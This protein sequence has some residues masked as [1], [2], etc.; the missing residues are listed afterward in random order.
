MRTAAVQRE[1]A[2][3]RVQVEDGRTL[4]QFFFFFLS[5]LLYTRF[6]LHTGRR[7]H[8][9]TPRPPQSALG[10]R[11]ICITAP[12]RRM[13][14]GRT[15]PA[16]AAAATAGGTPESSTSAPTLNTRSP[17]LSPADSAGEPGETSSTTAKPT[18]AAVAVVIAAPG[19]AAL[20]WGAAGRGRG[21]GGG[22]DVAI[23]VGPPPTPASPVAWAAA[24]RS[25]MTASMRLVRAL[26]SLDRTF[27]EEMVKVEC[28]RKRAV[29]FLLL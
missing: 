19:G 15:L 2:G 16:A 22:A 18:C 5:F 7:R 1:R 12:A 14:T 20:G 8:P 6:S 17:S 11:L 23:G 21:G 24:C 28:E 4:A 3:V 26:W 10:D 13:E 9:R 27:W 29:A 25:W